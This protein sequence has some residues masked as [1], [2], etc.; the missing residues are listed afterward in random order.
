[1][2]TSYTI[3]TK[4]IKNFILG[5]E[6]PSLFTR[7]V[8]WLN[9]PLALWYLIF[10]VLEFL[11]IRLVHTLKDS[12]EVLDRINEI[13]SNYGLSDIPQSFFLMSVSGLMGVALMIVGM[14]LFW[15]KIKW[16]YPVYLIGISIVFVSPMVFLGYTYFSEEQTILELLLPM[17][18]LVLVLIDWM[19]KS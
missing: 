15:R 12:E 4:T 19:R 1:M 7:I 14:L 11:A 2:T 18:A 3:R 8:F 9:V 17:L 16:G 13:G 6:S 5:K 10:F